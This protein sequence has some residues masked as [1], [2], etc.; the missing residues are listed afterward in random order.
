MARVELLPRRGTFCHV[1][2]TARRKKS[3]AITS[4]ST[5]AIF[6]RYC[7]LQRRYADTM[8]EVR[9]CLHAN[10]A[11]GTMGFGGRKKNDIP[12]AYRRDNA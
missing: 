12:A 11:G 9:L 6:G 10:A 8:L 4:L 1:L 7:C 5:M 2:A 3:S